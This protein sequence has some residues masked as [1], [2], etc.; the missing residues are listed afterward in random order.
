MIT[1]FKERKTWLLHLSFWCAYASFFFYYIAFRRGEMLT[2]WGR[3]I[4]DLS[5][6]VVTMI[7]ICYLNYFY[8][9]PRFLKRRNIGRYILEFLPLLIIFSYLVV[10]GKQFI[11]EFFDTRVDFLYS[12]K[13]Y[14]TFTLNTLFLVV[15][16][17]LLK[18]VEDW[19][20]LEAKRKEL[21]N[22]RLSSE[23]RFLRTQIHP[24]FL[25]NT[26]NNLYY[27]AYTNSPNTTE[28][29]AKLSQMMRYMIHDSNHSRVPLEKE[30]EY[31]ENYIKLEKLR[32][33]DN[34]PIELNIQGDPTGKN[35]APLILIT[36]LE[37]A[38]KH[39]VSNSAQQSWIKVNMDIREN[40][41]TYQVANS[42]IQESNKTFT[43]SSGIGL[44]NVR[45]RLELSYPDQYKLNIDDRDDQFS[46]DLK[47]LQI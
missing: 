17:G 6:Q 19:F 44:K 36:F 14:I 39:G 35:I 21:E 10:R 33:D 25:F 27:L 31:I 2:D 30:I 23:L 34:I 8:F 1:Y 5:F 43:E 9:L 42:R 40:S 28:V 26:L 15:F 32:L 37:N 45:R 47:L 7:I 24:H 46:V 16:I 41:L 11:L 18:F 38:F 20:D 12:P 22:E 29:I 13:F 4:T 3:I